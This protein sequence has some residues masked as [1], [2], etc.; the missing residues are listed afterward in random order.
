MSNQEHLCPYCGTPLSRG[1]IFC[2]NCGEAIPI[3]G[4]GAAPKKQPLETEASKTP[5]PDEDAPEASPID[6]PTEA[7]S[8][9]DPTGAELEADTEEEELDQE[10]INRKILLV[11]MAVMGIF[12]LIVCLLFRGNSAKPNEASDTAMEDT[13][14]VDTVD[15]VEEEEAPLEVKT[16]DYHINKLVEH[17]DSV[18]SFY[19]REK[20]TIEGWPVKIGDYNLH[21]LHICLA[22]L[23]NKKNTADPSNPLDVMEQLIREHGTIVRDATDDEPYSCSGYTSLEY[24]GLRR[25]RLVTFRA[26]FDGGGTLT[27]VNIFGYDIKEDHKVTVSSIVKGSNLRPFASALEHYGEHDEGRPGLNKDDVF[28]DLDGTGQVFFDSDG[29]FMG[30]ALFEDDKITIVFARPYIADYTVYL[31]ISMVNSPETNYHYFEPY[32]SEYIKKIYGLE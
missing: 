19:F 30:E 32:L 26:E 18:Y 15:V 29:Q 14:M 6:Q 11:S 13:A 27:D 1:A 8:D 12:I 25:N 21:N 23:L 17:N 22:K 24:K 16:R 9:Q 5:E 4:T 2:L 28:E 20:G 7:E 3:G 31:S 10:E